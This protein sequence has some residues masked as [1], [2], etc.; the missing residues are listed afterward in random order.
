VGVFG[1]AA[2]DFAG[3]AAVVLAF[4]IMA[5]IAALFLIFI[6]NRIELHDGWSAFTPQE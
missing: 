2:K 1:A 4:G 6:G 3:I 5:A